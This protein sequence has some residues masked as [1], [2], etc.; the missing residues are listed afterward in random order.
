MRLGG[1]GACHDH[2]SCRAEAGPSAPASMRPVS[3]HH[4]P[5]G[6]NKHFALAHSTVIGL[7]QSRALTPPR[8]GRGQSRRA[9][10]PIS[11]ANLRRR[12]A[13]QIVACMRI[14]PAIPGEFEL[15]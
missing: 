2:A 12:D 1:S 10:R 15:C 7:M 11:I 6:S 14:P 13:F 8:E 9:Q 3:F 5:A 4:L